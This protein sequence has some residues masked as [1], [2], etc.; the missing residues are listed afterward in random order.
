M[1]IS[2]KTLV[3]YTF[4]AW[5]VDSRTFQALNVDSRILN[6]LIQRS[7]MTKQQRAMTA[8]SVGMMIFLN[9]N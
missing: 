4:Y 1:N 2:L 3:I 9:R 6:L 5:N 8:V 7:T